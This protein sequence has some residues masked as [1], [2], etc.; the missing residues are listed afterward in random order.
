MAKDKEFRNRIGD[1]FTDKK[2]ETTANWNKAAEPVVEAAPGG[3]F[4]NRTPA[5][6]GYSSNITGGQV[7][8]R[9]SY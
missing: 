2:K 5:L 7:S 3:Y 6:G 1:A 8:G 9:F 4:S